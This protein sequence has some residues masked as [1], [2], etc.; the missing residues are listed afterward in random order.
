MKC[1]LDLILIY[2]MWF[3]EIETFENPKDFSKHK[4][5]HEFLHLV[6]KIALYESLRF[7]IS[8]HLANIHF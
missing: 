2:Y 3:G 8:H 1:S 7:L 6:A 4:F 5:K